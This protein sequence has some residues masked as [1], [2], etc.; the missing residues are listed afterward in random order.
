MID[1]YRAEYEQRSRSGKTELTIRV[2]DRIRNAGGR[3]LQR[4]DDLQ[5]EEVTDEKAVRSKISH[6]FRTKTT[7]DVSILDRWT[8]RAL[9]HP[10]SLSSEEDGDS[11]DEED[12][13]KQSKRPKL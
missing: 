3:F 7:L 1:H 4:R 12:N 2:A 9:H 10:S 11:S 8:A 6:S 13:G 5:W